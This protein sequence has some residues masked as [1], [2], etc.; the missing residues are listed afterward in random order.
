[1]QLPK[2]ASHHK[3][4]YLVIVIPSCLISFV[5]LLY[6]RTI[7]YSGTWSIMSPQD[8]MFS[9]VPSNIRCSNTLRYLGHGAGMGCGTRAV[10][11]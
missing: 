11:S 1:M 3:F 10:L 2:F 8:K 7:S 9:R 5:D 6:G 4:C